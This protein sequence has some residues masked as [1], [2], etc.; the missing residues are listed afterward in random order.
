MPFTLAV[1]DPFTGITH[2]ASHVNSIKR[3]FSK[4]HCVTLEGGDGEDKLSVN[5]K[6]AGQICSD[7]CLIHNDGAVHVLHLGFKKQAALFW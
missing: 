6:D 5:L 4:E 2:T 1:G 3:N 7:K